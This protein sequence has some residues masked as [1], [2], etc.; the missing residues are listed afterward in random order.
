MNSQP[1]GT[2]GG[3]TTI[4]PVTAA[5]GEA[6]PGGRDYR[7]GQSPGSFT[8]FGVTF[9]GGGETAGDGQFSGS[10]PGGGGAPGKAGGFLGG[11]TRGGD[12]AGG[13]AWYRFLVTPPVPAGWGA[14]GSINTSDDVIE[15]LHFEGA[16][17]EELWLDGV[18]V[19]DRGSNIETVTIVNNGEILEAQSQFRA[20]LTARGLDYKT[21]TTVPFRLDISQVKSLNAMFFGCSALTTVPEMDTS[22]V[23]DMAG[24]FN[25]CAALTQVPE[26]ETSQ[27]T[28]MGSMFSGC[29]ALTQVPDMDTGQVTNMGSMFSGCSA[30]TT[31]PEMDTGQVTNMG[32]M[33]SGCSALTQVPDMD[34]SQVTNMRNMLRNC[35]SL[36]DG[37]IRLIGKNKS[38]DTLTMITGSGLTRL[39]FYDKNGNWTG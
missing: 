23:T 1:G 14:E 5:G 35:S 18:L 26:M 34:T 2:S 17:I 36:T 37:H 12:G 15:S 13:A 21:V 22:H 24:I 4:G 3:A 32:S 8:A 6:G 28:G 31:V 25:G 10:R 38:L 19:W 39:P 9:A 29:S 30:L 33:F 11:G 20:A 7:P 27:V 16:E